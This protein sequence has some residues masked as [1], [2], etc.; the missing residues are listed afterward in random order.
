MWSFGFRGS[1]QKP[2]FFRVLG[3]QVSRSD[4]QW[5]S[6]LREAVH[7]SVLATRVPGYQSRSQGATHKSRQAKVVVLL[8]KTMGNNM[9]KLVA[10][11]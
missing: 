4:A 8:V 10:I 9:V 7:L 2:A 6:A 11:I 1:T 5:G 3:G